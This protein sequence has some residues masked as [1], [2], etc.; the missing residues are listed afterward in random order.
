[1]QSK[2]ISNFLTGIYQSIPPVYSAAIKADPLE[3]FSAEAILNIFL[4]L[5]CTTLSDCYLV[6]KDWKSVAHIF[7]N[8]KRELLYEKIV[9]SPKDWDLHFKDNGITDEEKLKAFQ[10]LPP[11]I[12]E[13]SCLIYPEKKLIETHVITYFP[14][15]I[16][17]NHYVELLEKKLGS[18]KG[19]DFIWKEII[20]KFGSILIEV[21]GWKAMTKQVLNNNYEKN[22]NVHK[23]KIEALKKT[24]FSYLKV[25][26][27]LEAIICIST[28]FFK[29]KEKIFNNHFTYCS[30]NINGY[31]AIVRY[32]YFGIYTN[33]EF[34]ASQYNIGVALIQELESKRTKK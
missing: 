15:K 7:L 17:I 1:M 31:Q 12:D 25:P 26:S 16:T 24:S 23:T 29:S 6:N 11:N 19:Y 27:L 28:S 20:P 9:F 34:A 30:E 5:N 18:T 10:S 13:L 3:K 4:R 33:L 21:S 14:R 8:K 2:Y 22:F 32:S